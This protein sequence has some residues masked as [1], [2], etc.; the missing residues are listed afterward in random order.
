MDGTFFEES[1]LKGIEPFSVMETFNSF[2]IQPIGRM[3]ENETGVDG[4]AV[5]EDG[6]GATLSVVT[7]VFDA[8]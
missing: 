1:I 8:I 2:D 6:A 3:H 4:I 7:A 5:D